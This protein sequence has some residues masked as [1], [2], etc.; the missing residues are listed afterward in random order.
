MY[1]GVLYIVAQCT[2]SIIATLLVVA[3]FP[4]D[5]DSKYSTAY[6]VYYCCYCYCYHCWRFAKASSTIKG[7][8]EGTEGIK[9]EG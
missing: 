3:S 8:V 2:G 5:K 9:W 4:R 1:V 7:W 6:M